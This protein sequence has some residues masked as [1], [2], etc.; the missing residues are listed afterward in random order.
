MGVKPSLCYHD[1]LSRTTVDRPGGELF[2]RMWLVLSWF[3]NLFICSL[4]RLGTTEHHF[5]PQKNRERLTIVGLRPFSWYASII[6]NFN[7]RGRSIKNQ[8]FWEIRLGQEVR[9]FLWS[10][11]KHIGT[12]EWPGLC[13]CSSI[14]IFRNRWKSHIYYETPCM[15]SNHAELCFSVLARTNS[16]LITL[17]IDYPCG[18][19]TDWPPFRL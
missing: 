8:W 9:K 14:T 19:R 16:G 13:G 11:A 1:P 5:D 6:A 15:Y 10:C 12:T 18:L 7:S 4:V 2:L 3:T 17:L